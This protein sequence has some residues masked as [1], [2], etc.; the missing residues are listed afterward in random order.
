MGRA[1]FPVELVSLIVEYL[2]GDR[3]SLRSVLLVSKT[4]AAQAIPI[5]WETPQPTDLAAI[6]DRGRQQ[7]YARYVRELRVNGPEGKYHDDFR[8]L[9]FPR[10]RSVVIDAQH[11]EAW[12]GQYI[13]PALERISCYAPLPAGNE[14]VLQ[15]LEKRCPRL[16]NV[17]IGCA[18]RGLN[19]G[20]L[21][22]F[23]DRCK[24]LRYLG[25][26]DGSTQHIDERVLFS[27]ASRDDLEGLE[28]EA[29]LAHDMFVS[30]FQQIDRPFKDIQQLQVQIESR[31]VPLLVPAVTNLRLLSLSLTDCD[32][33]PWPHLTPLTNLQDLTILYYG[34]AEISAND[35]QILKGWDLHR[36]IVGS[37]FGNVFAPTLTDD[38]FIPVVETL[39]NLREIE[40]GFE[41]S[42]TVRSL[43]SLGQSCLWLRDCII[44][45]TY[46]LSPWMDIDP[47]TPLFPRLEQLTVDTIEEIRPTP[48]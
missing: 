23:V 27:L 25:V 16:A 31:T 6:H 40:L 33:N 22:G 2:R 4:W 15:L 43:T 32:M 37:N 29:F 20:T 47:S 11:E 39:P 17:V 42:L 5:L 28:A 10:L 24:S 45:G 35:F 26:V 19:S 44:R 34:V 3:S 9:G 7:F 13:Q 38:E 18:L 8:T 48:L 30:L 41:N 36:L 12:I 46:D 21:C 1:Q 14:D